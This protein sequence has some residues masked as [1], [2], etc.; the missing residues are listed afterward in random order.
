M[1][2][3]TNDAAFLLSTIA[4]M[5]VV[6]AKELVNRQSAL[7][8]VMNSLRELQI[9]KTARRYGANAIEQAGNIS[10]GIVGAA[11]EMVAGAIPTPG[12]SNVHKFS[13]ACTLEE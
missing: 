12:R 11:S 13:R 2:N 7:S 5:A 9:A 3:K 10:S 4:G 1:V 8:S 6:R